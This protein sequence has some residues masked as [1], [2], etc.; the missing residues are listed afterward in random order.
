M[1]RIA[2]S[3][4]VLSLLIP[5]ATS[6]DKPAATNAL[7]TIYLSDS[8][9]SG[10]Y[11]AYATE[12][13]R[14]I[15]TDPTTPAARIALER[16]VAMESE[17][18][19]PRPVY[20]MLRKLAKQDFKGCGPWSP[21]YADAYVRL[22]RNYDTTSQWHAVAQRWRGITQAA[23]IGPFTDG[24]APAH[25]DVFGPEV[26]LDFGAEYDGAYGR[27]KWQAVR[28]HDP[29]GAELDIHDQ[30][31]WTG[32]GYYVATQIVSPEHRAA[33]LLIDVSGPAKV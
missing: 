9:R 21:E 27:V 32:Y 24:A 3:L 5:L 15:E 1:R 33:V 30:K 18:A 22:A 2:L 14:L 23:Y 20:A 6:Q 28:H 8:I 11:D 19:D 12:L 7:A 17:L 31:R 29:V 10:D 13:I 25:D 4:V 26:L 16:C